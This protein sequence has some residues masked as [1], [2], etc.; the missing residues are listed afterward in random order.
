MRS[1]LPIL[2]SGDG[3]CSDILVRFM[4]RVSKAVACFPATRQQQS[5]PFSTSAGPV[6]VAFCCRGACGEATNTTYLHRSCRHGR[7]GCVVRATGQCHRDSAGG[8]LRVRLA[9]HDS[10]DM[11]AMLARMPYVDLPDASLW[12]EDSGGDGAPVVFLHAFHGEHRGL[13]V[14][15]SRLHRRRLSLYHLRSQGLGT[16]AGLFNGRAG[17]L[18]ERRPARAGRAPGPPPLPPSGHRRGRVRCARLRGDASRSA[19]EPGRRLQ[20]RPDPA[21]R[22]VRGDRQ[23]VRTD[24]GVSVATSLVPRDRADVPGGE[25]GGGRPLDRDRTRQPAG[26]ERGGSGCATISRSPCWRR[27]ELPL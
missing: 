27:F 20:R 2:T 17:D 22:G 1:L 14:P 9:K 13:G 19:R 25:P 10:C 15:G 18:C 26:G 6:G 16:V 24:T 11:G 7:E 8:L 5:H 21:G 4:T 23:Q 3:V 12:Y